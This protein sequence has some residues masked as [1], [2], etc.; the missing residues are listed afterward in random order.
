MHQAR[1]VPSTAD[2]DRALRGAGLRVTRPRLAVLSA[3]RDH[4]HADTDSV[5]GAVRGSF[6]SVSPP[7]GLRRAARADRRRPGA[8]LPAERLG[9]ALRGPGRGQ[10]P[11]RRLPVV[12]RDRRRRLRG[13]RG[14]LPDRRRRRG[15]P[16]STRPRS[17]TGADAPDCLRR[18]YRD[19]PTQLV[20]SETNRTQSETGDRTVPDKDAPRRAPEREREPGDPVAAAETAHRPHTNKDWWPNQLDLSVLRQHNPRSNPMGEDFDYAEGVPEARRRGAQARPR[21]A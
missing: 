17:S 20:S 18:R 7:G 1:D 10:P 8:A 15:L 5:I 2:L 12:R 19:R 16:R 11:P 13:G 4:P 14:A 6:G 21:R 9:G 3:V